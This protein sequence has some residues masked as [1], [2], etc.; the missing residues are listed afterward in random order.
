MNLENYVLG[1]E[2]AEKGN[3][4][5]AN[6]S[7]LINEEFM[8]ENID[9]LK[10]GGITLLNKKCDVLPAY[11][12]KVIDTGTLSDLTGLIPKSFIKYELSEE[13]EDEDNIKLN[14]DGIEGV[15]PAT[16]KNYINKVKD[17]YEDIVVNKKAFVRITNDTLAEAFADRKNRAIM[18][19]S[20]FPEADEYVDGY[21]ELSS[22]KVL[23]WF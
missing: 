22:G 11:I 3:F 18:D 14:A 1:S 13:F 10:F 9:Y 7:M 16:T 17:M 12:R 23:A 5:I 21:M 19:A 15:Q 6:I 8:L 2:L 4:H 20:E